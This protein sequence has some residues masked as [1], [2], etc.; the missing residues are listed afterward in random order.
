MDDSGILRSNCHS[1]RNLGENGGQK[2]CVSDNGEGITKPDSFVVEIEGL[3]HLIENDINAN[4]RITKLQRKLTRK[5]S[6]R[7]VEKKITAHDRDN[8]TL[9]SSQRGIVSGSINSNGISSVVPE[10]PVGVV[11][12]GPTDHHHLVAVPQV[13]H[14]IT[15]LNSGCTSGK[16]FGFRRL[17]RAWILD[18]RKIFFFFATLSCMGTI[19]LIY[20]T[21]SMGRVVDGDDSIL[22]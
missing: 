14:Q 16:R 6:L 18:S 20:F 10:M 17:P 2:I 3:S 11:P 9:I 8:T 19:L 1:S 22:E 5:A 13:H 21:L 15:I 4:S 12:M 7:S